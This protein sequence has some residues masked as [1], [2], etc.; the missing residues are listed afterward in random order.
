MSVPS[1]LVPGRVARV[2]RGLVTLLLPD[3]STHRS[4]VP[5]GLEPALGDDVLLDGDRLLATILPRR[6]ELARRAGEG[7]RR[8][9]LA[10]NVDVV[11][12][13]RA[14][15]VAVRTSRINALVT[16]ARESGA[17]AVVVL[18]KAD[19][20]ADVDAVVA[21]VGAACG[22]V[23]ILAVSVQ[24]GLGVTEVHAVVAGRTAVLLGESGAGKST[25]TNALCGREVLATGAVR[26]DG[27]GRHTTTH[28]ELVLLPGGG[29]IIDTPGIR[30]AAAW[31]DEAGIGRA[32]ADVEVLAS[33]CRFTDCQHVTEPG[34]AIREALDAGA[35]TSDRLA[36]YDLAV[37]EQRFLELR[38]DLKARSEARVQ[39][40]Q[41]ARARRRDAW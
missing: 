21:E 12:V 26:R 19:R 37:R 40:R 6:T 27:A 38:D 31:H 17:E 9:I 32:F 34:C 8:Q 35:V 30:E 16:M 24:T 2:D 41:Q 23:P 15:D 20:H 18:T 39:R 7:N 36:A 4:P 28:R 11:L 5:R 10:A 29:S 13:V 25:L 22:A 14:L 3:G 1:D 33:S